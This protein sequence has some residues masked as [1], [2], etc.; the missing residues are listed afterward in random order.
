MITKFKIF[1]NEENEPQIVVCFEERYIH[2][3]GRE[4]KNKFDIFLSENI[5]QCIKI[6]KTEYYKTEYSIKYF[7]YPQKKDSICRIMYLYEIIFY[8]KDKSDCENYI[9]SKK[10][11]L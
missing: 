6:N 4:E 2:P 11:N 10:Y 9:I 7:N 5:G 8:S 3:P 1:K